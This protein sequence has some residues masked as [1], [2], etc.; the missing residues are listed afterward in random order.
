MSPEQRAGQLA[1]P[2]RQLAE[3]FQQLAEPAC[4][5]PKWRFMTISDRVQAEIR[6]ERPFFGVFLAS[7]IPLWNART[8]QRPPFSQ[9]LSEQHPE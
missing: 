2:F 4:A 6:E 9:T 7:P 5:P 3:L 8:K 1:E